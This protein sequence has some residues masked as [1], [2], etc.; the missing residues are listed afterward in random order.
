GSITVAEMVSLLRELARKIRL[1]QFYK[2][3]RGPK[4][5]PPKRTGGL[6]EKHVS[7]ARLLQQ[8]HL[9]IQQC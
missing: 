3:T 7:T 8:R 2:T 1:K 6:R 5:P 9:Q 4:K